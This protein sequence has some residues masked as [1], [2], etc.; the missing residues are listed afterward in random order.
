M[1]DKSKGSFVAGENKSVSHDS[2]LSSSGLC[3]EPTR[4][5]AGGYKPAS[6]KLDPQ[7]RIMTCSADPDDGA[8]PQQLPPGS[9]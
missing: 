7:S 3:S 2:E 6:R 5:Q 8:F 4:D 1:G 9:I